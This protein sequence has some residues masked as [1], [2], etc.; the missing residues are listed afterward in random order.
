MEEVIGIRP[1]TGSLKEYGI[2]YEQ[3]DLLFDQKFDY[4]NIKC[5][6]T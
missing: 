1:S 5:L 4:N 3:V 6:D 2:N